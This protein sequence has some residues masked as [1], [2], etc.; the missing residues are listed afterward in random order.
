MK[1][2]SQNYHA[3]LMKLVYIRWCFASPRPMC[4]FVGCGT[5]EDFDR[6]SIDAV[7]LASPQVLSR[8]LSILC[9]GSVSSDSP[10][11]IE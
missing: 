7:L 11:L 10:L 4:V 9:V 2:Y 3:P 1:K 8:A 6:Q 5:D